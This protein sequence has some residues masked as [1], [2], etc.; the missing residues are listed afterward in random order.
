MYGFSPNH[1][2]EVE[3]KKWEGQNKFKVDRA[4][5]LSYVPILHLFPLFTVLFY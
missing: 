1:S 3:L 5:P 2:S 4:L